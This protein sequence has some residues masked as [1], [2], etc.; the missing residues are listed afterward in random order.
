VRSQDARAVPRA[1]RWLIE[2]AGWMVPVSLRKSW[3]REWLA[4]V[5]HGHAAIL[6]ERG[7][8]PEAWRRVT[9]FAL[10]AFVDASDLRMEDLRTEF[11]GRGVVRHPAFCLGSLLLLF[12]SLA[13]WTGGFRHCRM[14][15]DS[16]YP[17]QEQ[18]VL[19][20]QPLAVLGMEAPADKHQVSSWV[21]SSRW[22]GD[23][24]G[25]VLHGSTL[26]VT[27]NFF[28]VLHIEPS[29]SFHF[30]GHSVR[31][32]RAL[33]PEDLPGRFS[34]AVARLKHPRDREAAEVHF[35]RFAIVDGTRV[36]ATFVAERDRWPLYF[37]GGGCLLF[38]AAGMIRSRRS[39]RY[40]AFFAAK[41][42]LLL[43]LVA[44]SW[45][46]GATTLP[47]PIT[48]GVDARTAGPLVLLFLMAAALALRWSLA[49]QDSRCPV[50]CR[51]VSM[52]V[53]VGSPSSLI[54]DRPGV[55]FLC[56]RGH[57]TL[58]LSDLRA[59]TGERSRWTPADRSWEEVF[60]GA[61]EA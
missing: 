42:T 41:T 13:G 26:E 43:G 29:A 28:S 6:R 10:G 48:G 51:V 4:E 12:L 49:D 55:Q 46:E 5:W 38:L 45:A 52:P 18:L 32:V 22:F 40:L 31:A 57:G 27:P 53:T 3:K 44:A 11:H 33:D 24:A 50:C 2:A 17:E 19:L 61:T 1:S 9:R 34:G 30:L 39:P 60:L 58:L 20:S 15:F 59:C 25:F 56:R 7:S 14:A 37:A 35:A 16:G 47:I 8:R 21:E 23:V 54:L 36:R